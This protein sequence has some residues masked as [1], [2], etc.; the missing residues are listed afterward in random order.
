MFATLRLTYKKEEKKQ[1]GV[2]EETKLEKPGF[3]QLPCGGI[4]AQG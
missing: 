4:V 3:D 2:K 1:K